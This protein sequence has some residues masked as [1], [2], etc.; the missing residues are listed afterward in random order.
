MAITTIIGIALLAFAA[1]LL[2]VVLGA[3]LR[4]RCTAHRR[5]QAGD[6]RDRTAEQSHTVNDRD[7]L[8]EQTAAQARL[9]HA[10]GDAKTAHAAGPKHQAQACR[11][12]VA[13]ACDDVKNEF[14]R[15]AG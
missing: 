12:D 4:Q 1:V 9:A 7:A 11:S 14:E 15:R 10:E 3:A 5:V 13:A 6:I 2:F 8:A